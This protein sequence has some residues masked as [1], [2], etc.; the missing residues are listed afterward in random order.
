MTEDEPLT[1]FYSLSPHRAEIIESLMD[2][3]EEVIIIP[4]PFRDRLKEKAESAG[5]RFLAVTINPET[6]TLWTYCLHD[7]LV[8]AYPFQGHSDD[9]LTEYCRVIVSVDFWSANL[10][11]K[12]NSLHPLPN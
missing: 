6:K 4:L 8:K 10:S 11:Q 3:D 12:Q 1:G 5:H 7:R 9:L 2:D